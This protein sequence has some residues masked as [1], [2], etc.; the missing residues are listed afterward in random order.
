MICGIVLAAGRS[1]RM[2]E[3]KALLSAGDGTFLQRAVRALREGGCA[4]V[5]VV[6][7]RLDDE[8]ARE[9]AEEAAMMDAGIAVN[10]AAESEQADSLRVGL[11]ALPP[12]AEAAVVP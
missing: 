10:T 2:G 4:Y 12:E 9:I 1:R 8:T 7:A 5:L 6:T 3:P 11:R